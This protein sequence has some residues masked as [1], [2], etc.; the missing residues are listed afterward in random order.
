MR[1]TQVVFLPKNGPV[2]DGTLLLP[3]M[4]VSEGVLPVIEQHLGEVDGSAALITSLKRGDL[5]C[6]DKLLLYTL[7]QIVEGERPKVIISRHEVK[8]N[9]MADT[10]NGLALVGDGFADDM[11]GWALVHISGERCSSQTAVTRCIYYQRYTT[12]E[13]LKEAAKTYGGLTRDVF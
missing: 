5:K 7:K 10:G 13:A 11:A 8:V 12:E 1:R 4:P 6:G 3:D 2:S 9:E